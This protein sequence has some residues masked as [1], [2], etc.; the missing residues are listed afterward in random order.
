MRKAEDILYDAQGLLSVG[1]FMAQQA[2]E[3]AVKA[4][5]K[6]PHREGGGEGMAFIACLRDKL[7]GI[8]KIPFKR[9]S[10]EEL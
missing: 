10:A 7:V 1:L 4:A 5:L 2:T 6:A 3:Q 9:S 8:T